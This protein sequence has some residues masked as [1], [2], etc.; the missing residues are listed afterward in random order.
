MIRKLGLSLKGFLKAKFAF[1][2]ALIL[3]N[4]SF[5]GE[6]LSCTYTDSKKEYFP[7]SGK[8]K[9]DL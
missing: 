3:W 2:G 8:N 5:N 9:N 7:I 1:L 4:A 6:S